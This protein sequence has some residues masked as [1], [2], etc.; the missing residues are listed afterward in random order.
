MRRV[1]AVIIGGGL[2][3][4]GAL[5]AGGSARAATAGT[6]PP[7][8]LRPVTFDGYEIDVPANWP[9][10]RLG[11]DP[12]QCVRYDVHAVYLGPPGANE[13]CP[14]GLIGRTETVSIVPPGHHGAAPDPDS[15]ELQV[16]P[17]GSAGV[18]VTA[19]YGSDRA[20]IEKVLGTLRTAPA[21]PVR[22]P[23][24]HLAEVAEPT[25]TLTPAPTLTPTPGLTPTPAPTLTL[26]SSPKLT[27]GSV[28]HGVVRHGAAA[29]LLGFDTCATPSLDTMRRWRP[30]YRA[31]GVY[32]G[33]VNAACYDGNVTTSW[34]A[35]VAGMGWWMLSAY[36]GPQAPCYGYGT[37]ITPAKAAAQGTAAADDAAGDARQLR[38]PAR[39]PIYY[40]MEA[41]NSKDASCRS[42]VLTFLSAWTREVNA[43]GYA[44]GVYASLSSGISDMQAATSSGKQHFTPPQAIWYA[45]WDR[46]A[47]LNDGHLS[48]PGSDRAKQFRG[49]HDIT[50][51]GI[52]LNID[53]DLVAGPTVGDRPDSS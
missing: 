27:P 39:S 14:A 37:M 29:P 49:P 4:G 42:A 2:L 22:P 43:K 46:Q 40:D 25:L 23:I 16:T 50:I 41:Y 8:G 7:A 52:T 1:I 6:V 44:S 5:P 47:E 12:S 18:A 17:P 10:F 11:A 33:G 38:L 15:H 3:L 31:I 20:L 9:V 30:Y 45:R 13:Q 21:A 35:S 36:V 19:T 32:I 28:W 24:A 53:T 48:W 51:D 26:T 34:I